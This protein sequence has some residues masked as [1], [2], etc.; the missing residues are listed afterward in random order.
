MSQAHHFENLEA[1]PKV[2]LP[3]NFYA[4]TGAMAAIG[5]VA[6][7]V[8]FFVLQDPARTWKAYLIGFV[9]FTMVALSGPFFAATQ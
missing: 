3:K 7:L 2:Q 5:L 4:I 9:F 6:L 8:G 1:P